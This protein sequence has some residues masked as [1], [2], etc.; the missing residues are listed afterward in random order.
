M[1]S[2]WKYVAGGF[3]EPTPVFP[4]EAV[5]PCLLIQCLTWLR[6]TQLLWIVIVDSVCTNTHIHATHTHTHTHIHTP[7]QWYSITFTSSMTLSSRV[8]R[9]EIISHF[10][11]P[12]WG[13]QMSQFA[14]D[15]RVSQDEGPSV[16]KQGKS[17]DQSERVDSPTPEFLEARELRLRGS[18]PPHPSTL[19]LKLV[20]APS[21]RRRLMEWM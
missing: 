2:W 17:Q 20:A 19:A 4:L 14:L 9:T 1:I 3:W 7:R 11:T 13:A 15:W 12:E 6:R 16:L 18:V 8:L 10:L 21:L 5:L